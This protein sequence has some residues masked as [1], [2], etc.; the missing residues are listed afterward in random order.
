[1]NPE[2]KAKW[3]EALRSGKYRQGQDFLKNGNTFCCLGVLREIIEPGSEE[4]DDRGAQ[5]LHPKFCAIAG[6]EPH[7]VGKTNDVYVLAHMNDDG[8]PFSEI[9]YWIEK[10]L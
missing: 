6:L 8:K 10:N 3:V 1:M 9:A 2:I 5:Y 4:L 7:K